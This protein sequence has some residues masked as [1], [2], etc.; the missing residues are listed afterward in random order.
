M[1][2]SIV[3]FFWFVLPNVGLALAQ[4]QAEKVN[5]GIFSG[6][7]SAVLMGVGVLLIFVLVRRLM[8]KW[9]KPDLPE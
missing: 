4:E 5:D 6:R 1:K 9:K 3:S 2:K 8:G 7:Y